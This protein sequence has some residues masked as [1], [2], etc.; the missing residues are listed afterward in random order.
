MHER[1]PF[2]R[3]LHAM[4]EILQEWSADRDPLKKNCKFFSQ[5]P[6][7]N[8]QLQTA[9][10]HWSISEPKFIQVKDV[11]YVY[12]TASKSSRAK[13][14]KKYISSFAKCNWGTFDIY[15]QIRNSIWAVNL[16]KDTC[17]CREFFK[18]YICK[19]LV[20]LQYKLQI[21]PPPDAAKSLPLGEKRKRGRPKKALK[22][23]IIQ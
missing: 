14:E 12:S 13:I 3:F 2:P 18:K 22:A 23:L 5:K 17:T 15:S 21:I 10:F 1:L 4:K 16:H 6:S 20:G 9:A 11:H 19:H 7:Q 8:L